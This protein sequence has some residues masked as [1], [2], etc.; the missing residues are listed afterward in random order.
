MLEN[1]LLLL[2]NIELK[3]KY[4]PIEDK[5]YPYIC[6]CFWELRNAVADLEK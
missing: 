3:L 2:K 4:T 1:Y 6:S 5:S